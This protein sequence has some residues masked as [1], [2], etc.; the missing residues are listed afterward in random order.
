M[1]PSSPSLREHPGVEDIKMTSNDWNR[2]GDRQNAG[3]RTRSTDQPTHN[4]LRYLVSVPDGRH[5]N[6]GPPER[7]RDAV[8]SGSV[9]VELGVVDCA[10]VEHHAGA[11]C[12]D[13]DAETFDARSKRRNQHLHVVQTNH[14]QD[15][16]D[17]SRI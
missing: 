4:A 12:Y 15:N 14:A 17:I 2:N 8:D 9:D 11:Q 3:Q 13:E 1:D 16:E 7:I 6:D 10:R 5:G